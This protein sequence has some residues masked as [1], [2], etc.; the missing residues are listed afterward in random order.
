MD[1]LTVYYKNICEQLQEK[2]ATIEMQLN[3]AGLKRALKTKKSKL[4]RKEELKGEAR[5]DRALEASREA[6]S[7]KSKAMV[8]YGASSPEVGPPAMEQ[9]R[10]Y[11]KA[12][13]IISNLA[14]IDR[15]RE[16][17]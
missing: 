9:E 8:E 17:Y 6:G 10:Q 7:K 16:E 4:L 12:Q 14:K 2:I 13:R 5:A 11:A 1:Y 3:E 15:A